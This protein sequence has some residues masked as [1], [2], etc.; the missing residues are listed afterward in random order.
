[1]IVAHNMRIRIGA[2]AL[3]LA[4]A[5]LAVRGLLPAGFWSKYLGVA[6]WAALVYALVLFVR[7]RISVWWCAGLALAISWTVEFAQLTPGPAWL[8]SKHALLRAIFGALF[9]VYDLP[10]YAAGVLA[11]ASAHAWCKHRRP[12]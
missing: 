12:L 9:S 2:I 10:A 11:G 4:C 6:L 3:S 7:P 1:M 5:G 8:S